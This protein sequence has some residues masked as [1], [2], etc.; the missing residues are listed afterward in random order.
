M[1]ARRTRSRSI[2]DT[3]DNVDFTCPQCGQGS[4]CDQHCFQLQDLDRI[5]TCTHCQSTSKVQLWMCSCSLFWHACRIHDR[6]PEAQRR[7]NDTN[8][9][10]TLC[11]KGK[12]APK[13]ILSIMSAKTRGN[14]AMTLNFF[15]TILSPCQVFG[16]TISIH[17]KKANNNQ[18]AT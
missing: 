15:F 18:Y 10:D 7:Q 4:S 2:C 8:K 9:Q 12:I 14:K 11:S 6:W 16:S 17:Y 1:I 5:N 13:L 3:Y